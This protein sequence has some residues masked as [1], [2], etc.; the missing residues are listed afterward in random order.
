MPAQ[1]QILYPGL[2]PGVCDFCA[3]DAVGQKH[4][5]DDAPPQTTLVYQ[6]PETKCCYCLA[7]LA[8]AVDPANQLEELPE[9]PEITA[10]AQTIIADL[11]KKKN[12]ARN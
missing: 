12:H 3:M 8:E 11:R 1:E 10:M 5:L 2:T 7:C 4:L 9:D 6:D